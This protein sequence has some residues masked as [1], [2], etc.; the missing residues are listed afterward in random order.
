MVGH[1]LL[2]LLRCRACG[3]PALGATCVHVSY[4]RM[5]A[6]TF[7]PVVLSRTAF[8]LRFPGRARIVWRLD[9][10]LLRFA[11]DVAQRGSMRRG[12]GGGGECVCMRVEGVEV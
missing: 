7:F 6:G 9:A 11:A 12:G 2:A 8:P 10:V 1:F 5:Y 4:A 3:L